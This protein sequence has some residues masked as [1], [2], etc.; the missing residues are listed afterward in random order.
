MVLY[1]AVC[2]MK[3]YSSRSH[4]ERRAFHI[5]CKT[6][7]YSGACLAVRARDRQM[8]RYGFSSVHCS[9]FMAMFCFPTCPYIIQLSVGGEKMLP[10]H[11]ILFTITSLSSLRLSLIPACLVQYC[12]LCPFSTSKSILK[13]NLASQLISMLRYPVRARPPV[14]YRMYVLSALLFSK[15]LCIIA[16]VHRSRRGA[17]F[18]TTAPVAASV[19]WVDIYRA[20]DGLDRRITEVMEGLRVQEGLLLSQALF[21]ELPFVP[22]LN[23]RLCVGVEGG[24]GGC[25]ATGERAPGHTVKHTYIEKR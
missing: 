13:K 1:S 14:Q 4:Q 21:K 9:V 5:L 16:L 17:H 3:A 20:G 10:S 12:Y 18:P 7:K 24:D 11:M 8:L 6:G 22:E 2:N 19:A 15:G 23:H 25:H